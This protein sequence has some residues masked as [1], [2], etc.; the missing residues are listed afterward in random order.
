MNR[1]QASSL[2]QLVVDLFEMIVKHSNVSNVPAPNEHARQGFSGFIHD[3]PKQ[4]FG[5]DFR[6]HMASLCGPTP[7]VEA[8]IG[9]LMQGGLFERDICT[10]KFLSAVDTNTQRS[11]LFKRV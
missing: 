8:C 11:P 7:M 6:G 5:S 4:Y 1:R 2:A 9:T 10:E 3:A